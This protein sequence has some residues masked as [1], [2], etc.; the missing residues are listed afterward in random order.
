MTRVW[1]L[2][3]L[4]VVW[5]IAAPAMARTM[6]G[7]VIVVIDGDT[8]LFKPDRANPDHHGAAS[9]AF[10]KLRLA[11]IDAPEHDQPYGDAATDALSAL[12]LNRRVAVETVATDVYRRTIARIR[13]G[14][15]EVDA[16][17]VRDGFAW[18]YGSTRAS[19]G[20][21]PE[22]FATTPR[23]R[24]AAE[25]LKAQHQ[26]RQARRGLWQEPT[27]IP[28][29]VWRRTHATVSERSVSR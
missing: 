20:R 14:T 9:R 18:A 5:A 24:R 3:L 6:Y 12:V 28:P 26:A 13:I 29:W 23:S 11:D 10:L 22:S 25:L 8:V 16:A 27:P 2:G 19:A 15:L 7:V 21:G 1:A 4:L 17:L